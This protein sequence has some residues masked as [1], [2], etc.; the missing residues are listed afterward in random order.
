MDMHLRIDV[1][2]DSSIFAS[3]TC[4]CGCNP[5][6]ALKAGTDVA[7]EGCC[8]GNEFAVG[9]GARRSLESRGFAAR[10][11]FALQVI[12]VQA[13]W[14][15]QIDA[16]WAIGQSGHPADGGHGHGHETGGHGHAGHGH[17]HGGDGGGLPAGKALDP[18]CGMTVDVE[19]ARSKGLVFTYKGQDYYFCGKGCRLDFE[20]EPERILDPRYIPSM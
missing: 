6:V 8:C 11:G 17:G 5:G 18:V 15:E 19:T 7:T 1:K 14:G 4:P 12:P 3:Y 16:A 9:H 2:P 10:P 13:P 20:E